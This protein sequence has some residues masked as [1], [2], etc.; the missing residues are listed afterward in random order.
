MTYKYLCLIFDITPTVCSCSVN[1]KLKKVVRL[2]RGHPFVRVKFP[3]REQMREFANMARMREPMADNIIGFMDGVSFLVECTN[4]RMEQN[5]IYCSY[6]CN[7]M[8]N[9]VFAYGPD[10]KVFFASINFPGRWVDGSLMASFMRHIKSK[11]KNYKI[12]ID[13]GFPRSGEAR[14]ACWANHKQDSATSSL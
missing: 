5:A 2:L 4:D 6:N 9:N 1:W 12:C 10:G 8:V 3:N 13:Q 14:Y 7:T 11:I